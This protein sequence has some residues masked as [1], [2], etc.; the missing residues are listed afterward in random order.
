MTQLRVPPITLDPLQ[1]MAVQAGDGPVL[2][3]GGHGSGKTHA[4]VARIGILLDRGMPPDE[5][6][7]ITGTLHGTADLRRRLSE[8]SKTK[9]VYGRMFIGTMVDLALLLLRSHGIQVGQSPHPFTV[10]SRQQAAAAFYDVAREAHRTHAK[11][12][13]KEQ[14]LKSGELERAWRWYQMNRTRHADSPLLAELPWWLDARNSYNGEKDCEGVL[15]V[16]DLVPLALRVMDRQEDI[17]QSWQTLFSHFLV[18]DFQNLSAAETDLLMELTLPARAVTATASPNE[19]IGFATDPESWERLGLEMDPLRQRR[20]HL[21]VQHGS[22]ALLAGAGI[23]MAAHPS[24]T[25]LTDDELTPIR[26]PGER[27]VLMEY[28]GLPQDMCR[29]VIAMLRRMHDRE[30]YAWRDMACIYPHPLFHRLRT[31]VISEQIPYTVLGERLPR[32]ADVESVIAMLSLVL[33]PSDFQAFRR[34][35]SVDQSPSRD[36]NAAA[37]AGIRATALEGDGD[38]VQA[39]ESHLAGHR[40]DSRVYRDL[41]Y[42]TEV[43]RELNGLATQRPGT[44]V[45]LLTQTAAGMLAQH[46]KRRLE[47]SPT[48]QMLLLLQIAAHWEAVGDDPFRELGRFLDLLNIEPAI[49]P[50]GRER[51]DPCGPGDAV[52][53]GTIQAFAGLRARMVVVLDARDDVMPGQVHPDD[54]ERLPAEQRRFHVACTR[55]SERLILCYAT[56]SGSNRASRPT[57]FLD[58]LG[59]D[60]LAKFTVP[61]TEPW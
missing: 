51:N 35:A 14:K 10:R 46:Q 57:R 59:N 20:H 38:L 43:W 39:A 33:N 37:A 42:V 44:D 11:E 3:E 22:T 27:A 50:L 31:L 28:D 19:R 16:L 30:G 12:V 25:G 32:D 61:L 13:L 36:L 8:F 5:I 6:A 54:G 47:G 1:Q 26:I 4:V 21:R 2:I 23:A 17:Q 48:R 29:Q 49:D 53:F 9:E 56:R 34:A 18:D 58:H 52:V 60:I 41:R 15:D 24:M 55:A 45:G 40:Y 7:C